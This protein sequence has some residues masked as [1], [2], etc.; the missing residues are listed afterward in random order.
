MKIPG[1]SRSIGRG[2]RKTSGRY[3]GG[4]HLT[5]EFRSDEPGPED[6]RLAPTHGWLHIACQEDMKN[7]VSQEDQPLKQS[8]A[9]RAKQSRALSQ[10]PMTALSGASLRCSGRAA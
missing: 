1:A 10:F 9:S 8:R 3:A 7:V 6:F 5:V 4:D 2:E